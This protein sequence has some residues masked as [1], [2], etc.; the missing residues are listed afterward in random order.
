MRT[1]N[2]LHEQ[3][4]QAIEIARSG[5]YHLQPVRPP[6]TTITLQDPAADAGIR[7]GHVKLSQLLTLMDYDG[8][9]PA[10]IWREC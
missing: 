4:S 5:D 1:H 7:A 9:W 6:R 8:D 10:D 2:M 3:Y